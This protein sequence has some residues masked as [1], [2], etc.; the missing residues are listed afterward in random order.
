MYSQTC[1]NDH[2]HKTTT[3]LRQPVQSPPK[4]IPIQSLLYKT[5]NCLM[6]PTSDHFFVSQVK[7]NLSKTTATKLYPAKK[8]ET[9]IET[10]H[11]K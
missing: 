11:K 8:W 7:K 3:R 6:R 4:Q 9:I 2:L 1:L 10:I 5:T